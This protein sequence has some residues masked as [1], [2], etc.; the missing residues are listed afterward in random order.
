MTSL[1]LELLADSGLGFQDVIL[2][3]PVMRE[4]IPALEFYKAKEEGRDPEDL[5]LPSGTEI[6]AK[7]QE[8][9][10][11]FWFDY[12]FDS[13]QDFLTVETQ[14]KTLRNIRSR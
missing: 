9:A 1:D 6:T 4:M 3:L 7:Q 14:Q 10:A 5:T 12:G 11:E 8:E 13:L 2:G